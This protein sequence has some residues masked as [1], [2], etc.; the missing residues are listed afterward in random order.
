M[1][2]ENHWPEFEKI[3]AFSM[4]FIL[5]EKPMGKRVLCRERRC[6]LLCLISVLHNHIFYL[7][8]TMCI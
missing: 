5:V 8:S 1:A 7:Y 2:T 4:V 6:R 3:P